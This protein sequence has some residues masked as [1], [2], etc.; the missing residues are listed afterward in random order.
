MLVSDAL[1]FLI[2]RYRGSHTIEKT[3][4]LILGARL[5]TRSGALAACHSKANK[6]AKLVESKVCCI[7]ES[8]HLGGRTD[9]CP[10]A[11]FPSQWA[12]AF[13]G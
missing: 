2:C 3:T 11:D 12:R 8:G 5:V 9:S 10:K 7:L 13:I 1:W 6:G 4:C